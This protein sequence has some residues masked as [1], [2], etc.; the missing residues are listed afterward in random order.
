MEGL[1]GRAHPAERL[2]A[3]VERAVASHGGLVLVTGEAGIGKSTLVAAMADEARGQ[4]ALVL[5]GACWDSDSAPGYWPW[6]Q[7]IRAVR[8][9]ATPV[10]WERAPQALS[11][12]LGE[13]EAEAVMEADEFQLYDAVT[14]V[15][16]TLS[17]SRPVVVVL[18]DLHWADPASLRLLEFA[19]Q[20]TWFERLLLV[21]TYRDV[22][23][24]HPGH[25]LGP[26][27]LPL[28]AKATTITLT[29][30]DP[31]E[32]GELMAR[33]SG[34][35]PDPGQIAEVHHRTGGNPFFV[36]Q[37]A[38]L[39]GSGGSVTAVAP[40]V[41]EALRRR[42]SLLPAPV[43]ELLTL[44]AVLGRQFHR[45]V[46]AVCAA[47]PVPQVDRM[48]EQAVAT[49]LV[50]VRG[51]GAFSFAH[52]LVR[53][54]LYDSADAP[55]LHAQ[56]VQE[57]D[58]APSLAGKVLPAD[59]ARHAYL[60]GPSL[61][62]ARRIQVIRDAATDASCRMAI[63]ECVGHLRRALDLVEDPRTRFLIMCDLGNS[64]R[65]FEKNHDEMW[66]VYEQ[67]AAQARELDDPELL[68]RAGLTLHP[69]PGGPAQKALAR[70]LLVD[71][72]TALLGSDPA[73]LSEDRL[74]DE[75]TRHLASLARS[76]NDDDSLSFSLWARHET[77]WGLGSA[78][79][80]VLLTDELMAVARRRGDPDTEQFA[81]SLRWV[82]LLELGDPRFHDQYLAFIALA[83]RQA[84]LRFSFASDID[85]S[86]ITA[87][88]G[89][90][91]EAES[92]LTRSLR[93]E[94]EHEGVYGYMG[95]HMAWALLYAQGRFAEL[96]EVIRSMA[97]RNHPCLGMIE[98]LSALALG[99]VEEAR[100]HYTDEPYPR[101][102]EPLSLRFH[103][104]LAA[105]TGDHELAAC[106]RRQLAPYQGQWLVSLYGCDISGP[107]DHWMAIIDAAEG[108]WEDAIDGFTAA[109][110]SAERLGSRTWS[111]EAS[112]Q[113][114]HALEATGDPRAPAM[115]AEVEREATELGM[116]HLIAQP[117][118]PEPHPPS[119]QVFRRDG[120][121]WQL[122]YQG[123]EAHVPDAKGLRDLHAL[124][125]RPGTELSAVELLDPAAGPELV[126]ARRLGGDAV[127]DD[128]A[129]ARYRR[130]LE[131]LDDLL[132]RAVELGQ[133]TRAADLDRERQALLDELRAAAGL[134]GR[135]RRLGD[136]TERARKTVTARIR[137][138]L[139]KLD[140]VHPELAAH[141]R[142]SVSTGTTC[143]YRPEHP[144]VWDL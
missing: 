48:I 138:S 132:D 120:A 55:H 6:T 104:L 86:L 20:H 15:L 116:R 77:I 102:F 84:T 125:S 33:T 117:A 25:P 111:V 19:A 31:Q 76:G 115:R 23:V 60:A 126:A 61:N 91:A 32:V 47:M 1:I 70:S 10:E 27:I 53:E 14:T 127:L 67:A 9:H 63:E 75:L 73:A 29:G 7:V 74:A 24:E 112:A 131:E 106:T 89:D 90:F 88:R 133:D 36:E 140:P 28:V 71:A 8:R 66:E 44:A 68:A 143:C 134:A 107:V 50:T 80:R 139:R 119:G 100:R 59:L 41:Q 99:D 118:P 46:L 103:A 58:K 87:L 13:A 144:S 97:D 141:L 109:R 135:D 128:E 43:V 110:T 38:R 129:K 113:L 105:A 69:A 93:A 95:D 40:G 34:L 21:G 12:L 79:E 124:L 52:D 121:V 136:E 64:L 22:E 11:V 3:E 72:Y 42:L 130:R 2:R 49:R 137:D 114:A 82:A 78:T 122:C 17:Q 39:W 62:N 57:L 51:A 101:M 108:R 81:S 98:G 16:V 85:R 92:L 65:H 5:N 30:L 94:G 45:Q 4:G 142:A 56:V 96:G 123:R 18:E 54:T 35:D 83:E 37:T 26:R